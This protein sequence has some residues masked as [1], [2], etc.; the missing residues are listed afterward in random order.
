MRATQKTRLLQSFSSAQRD[1]KNVALKVPVASLEA[2]VDQATHPRSN[3]TFGNADHL[4]RR[5]ARRRTVEDFERRKDVEVYRGE[6]RAFVVGRD[7]PRQALARRSQ[8][9]QKR[10]LPARNIEIFEKCVAENRFLEGEREISRDV[11]DVGVLDRNVERFER[12]MRQKF[13]D[14]RDLDAPL[15]RRPAP[16]TVQTES[17]QAGKTRRE[18]ANV[19]ASTLAQR[20]VRPTFQSR[21]RERRGSQ[22][23]RKVTSDKRVSASSRQVSQNEAHACISERVA[24]TLGQVHQ[25]RR[26]RV[27]ARRCHR[28]HLAPQTP[29][30]GQQYPAQPKVACLVPTDELESGKDSF[31]HNICEHRAKVQKKENRHTSAWLGEWWHRGS[32]TTRSVPRGGDENSGGPWRLEIGVAEGGK[33]RNTLSTAG[34]VALTFFSVT[35]GPFGQELIVKAAG[36]ALALLGYLLFT[37]FWSVPE[38]LMTAELSVA[39]PEAAGFAAWTNAAFGPLAAWIDAWCS[40][41]SGVVDNAV[42]PILFLEYLDQV[43]DAFGHDHPVARWAF[44]LVFVGSLTYLCHRGLDLTGRSALVLTVFVLAPFVVFCVVAVPKTKPGR[45]LETRS[46]GLRQRAWI[47]NL[48]WN[49]NYFDSASAWAG[50][51]DRGSWGK[52]MTAA[53]LLC[54][55]ASVFPMLAATGATDRKAQDY[56]NGAY[57]DVARQISGP[58]LARWIVVAAAIANVGLFVSEMSS[59]A[60]QLMGMAERGLLPACLAKKSK[61]TDTPTN[62]IV[63]SALGVIALH[64]LTF[65]SIIATENLLYC[66]SMGVELAA[67]VVLVKKQPRLSRLTSKTLAFICTPAIILLVVVAAVQPLLV[68]I[69]AGA[70]FLLGIL[71][72]SAIGPTRRYNPCGIRYR[73]LHPDW[74]APT[75][76]LS[77]MCSWDERGGSIDVDDDDNDENCAVDTTQSQPR[78][79]RVATEDSQTTSYIEPLVPSAQGRN[80][81]AFV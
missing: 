1:Q 4:C 47:N 18:K 14:G 32:M 45:W 64:S 42:Y 19:E 24:F 29:M 33:K 36:P 53:V 58:W 39:Y 55:C 48:F 73:R 72:Y 80:E 79:F 77:S 26:H 27:A 65:E 28:A 17:P 13:E 81:S 70:L 7:Q 59:D 74:M 46:G 62:A 6:R 57:V 30:G 20:Q 44:T 3:E 41:V 31:L 60:Y 78:H 35:G 43:T 69:I 56:H 54:T 34:L 2:K 21:F 75:G 68:W 9:G 8:L 63:L 11:G 25:R 67:F 76:S 40:W 49:V 38:A 61:V 52:A 22:F 15:Y 23:L 50:D 16:H 66:V 37:M 51:V 10:E 5:D 71:I 12:A